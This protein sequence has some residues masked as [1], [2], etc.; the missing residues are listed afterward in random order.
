MG[1]RI[2][3]ATLALAL[4]VAPLSGCGNDPGA[5][6]ATSS[7]PTAGGGPAGGGAPPATPEKPK[8]PGGKTAKGLEPAKAD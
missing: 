7:G 4:A 6:T 2:R 3:F 8:G 5:P 1:R